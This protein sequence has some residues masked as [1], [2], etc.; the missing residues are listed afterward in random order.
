[1][2]RGPA[3][4][5]VGRGG[6]GA[7]ARRRLRSGPSRR[8]SARGARVRPPRRRPPAALSRGG[9]RDDDD[10]VSV[11]ENGTYL[12]APPNSNF[13]NSAWC[14]ADVVGVDRA[15]RRVRVLYA[16]GEDEWIDLAAESA[17]GA[18]RVAPL[19]AFWP[20]LAPGLAP[21]S[22]RPAGH[23][24]VGWRVALYCSQEAAFFAADVTG[25]DARTGLHRLAYADGSGIV[26]D[27][28]LDAEAVKWVSPPECSASVLAASVS[29]RIQTSSCLPP[30]SP[31]P[32]NTNALAAPPS[33]PSPDA[34]RAGS[35][36]FSGNENEEA[37]TE[38]AR[39]SN[40]NLAAYGSM[41]SVSC[42][43][44]AAAVAALA[45]SQRDALEAAGAAAAA[46]AA[47]VVANGAGSW[48]PMDAEEDPWAAG[49]DVDDVA[50]AVAA[51]PSSS[52]PPPNGSG[53][54]SGNGN[55]S[56]EMA[57]AAAWWKG[58]ASAAAGV[59]RLTLGAGVAA[60]AA[61]GNAC[62]LRTSAVAG[63]A[64]ED[65]DSKDSAVSCDA[66]AGR[67]GSSSP[68]TPTTA[69]NKACAASA[70]AFADAA[71]ALDVP[72]PRAAAAVIAGGCAGSS[73]EDG[74]VHGSV[75]PLAALLP[76]PGS[77]AFSGSNN[78][79]NSNNNA[80]N[81]SSSRGFDS[82]AADFHANFHGGACG[83]LVGCG[84]TA[85]AAVA[86]LAFDTFLGGDYGNDGDGGGNGAAAERGLLDASALGW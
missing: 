77:L 2:R 60:T 8:R 36:S 12:L 13:G 31:A 62:L 26:E 58:D 63:G 40:T 18:A 86:A 76:Q 49:D 81:A 64:E 19:G 59:A 83:A 53:N 79:I 4:G 56:D 23:A 41:G 69:S 82:A 61:V 34:C 74:S 80:N 55:G 3:G 25:F 47:A 32:N 5:G 38:G 7:E 57:A 51:L 16:D 30:H 70:S 20:P 39:A 22:L 65:G 45:A 66:G 10:D 11:V 78:N 73:P 54:G 17:R 67:G 14:R 84:G 85:T 71:P 68:A 33:P 29:K 37:T 1:M 46:A 72:A 6:R 24:A 21:G 42:D 35:S 15:A 27:A 44:A 28:R 75:A 43:A 50:A 52:A 9:E 48:D